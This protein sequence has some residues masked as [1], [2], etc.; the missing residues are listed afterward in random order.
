MAQLPVN[1]TER[2][3][4]NIS[5]WNCYIQRVH[6]NQFQSFV[7]FRANDYQ[8][9]RH[10]CYHFER[11]TTF[12]VAVSFPINDGQA[13]LFQEPTLQQAKGSMREG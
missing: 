13:T 5:Q 8:A 4:V 7:G 12:N 11:S 3:P 6:F 10:F 9:S 1:P 2:F